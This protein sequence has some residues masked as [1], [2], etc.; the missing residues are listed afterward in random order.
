MTLYR[1]RNVSSTPQVIRIDMNACPESVLKP[2]VPPVGIYHSI[3]WAYFSV[4]DIAQAYY[5]MLY[6]SSVA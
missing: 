1:G 6:T 2:R 4:T 3:A 5:P